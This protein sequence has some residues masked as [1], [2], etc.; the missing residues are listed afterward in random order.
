MRIVHIA[1]L[2]LGHSLNGWSREA[3]HRLWLSR[4]ADLIE[5]QRADALLI[6]GDVF[7]GLNPSGESQRLL[8]DSLVEFRTRRPGLITVI[9][10]GNHDP[11]HRL[12]APGALMAGI[13][14]HVIGTVRRR[15]GI[16]DIERHMVAL[17]DGSGEIRAYAVTIPFLRPAD[18]PDLNFAATE[19]GSPIV[20]AAANFHRDI[21]D[22]AEA[23]AG[24]LPLIAMG[25]LHCSGALE[26]EGAERRIPIGGEHAV[27]TSIF[28]ESFR[29]V[30][31]GHLHGPQSLD[32]GRIRYSGSCFPLS[33]AE[34]GHR[35][36]ATVIEVDGDKVT[37][38]H[39]EIPRP[40]TFHR[41]PATGALD[42][43][44][45]E[46]AIADLD[47]DSET[48]RDLQPFVY[49][50]LEATG[51]ASVVLTA[52]EKILADKPLRTALI[53]V[54]RRDEDREAVADLPASLSE[55][56]P[57]DLFL[58]AFEKA[59]QVPPEARHVTAFRDAMNGAD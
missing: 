43:A 3:E 1:D 22:R 52:A 53:R 41:I 46:L 18:L 56:N 17:R 23:L 7:D 8:Y 24:G 37:H 39:V 9:S 29:Y 11:C 21:A 6:A 28:P 57:E 15:D 49:L 30:A 2:H 20:R 51:P 27:P 36:G 13:D 32:K 38:E 26:S 4:L 34:I 48:P 19:D 14:A 58:P 5:D 44:E 35:H 25:H 31:L 50:T 40:A 10:S 47:L 54:A 16:I 42:P 45:L 33:V 59:N 12:E 55:I